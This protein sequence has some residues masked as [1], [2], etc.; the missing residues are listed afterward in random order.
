VA[1]GLVG[2]AIGTETF[3]SILAPAGICGA[4]GLRPTFGRVSRHGVMTLSWTLDK[5]GPLC[6]SVE[7]G[8]LVLAAIQ[9]PDGQDLSVQDVPFN[10]DA[11]RDRRSLRVG[12]LKA[13]FEKTNQSE[14][15]DANDA[16]ALAKLRG[17]GFSL[18]EVTLPETI[19]GLLR[20]IQWSEMNAALKEPY[21]TQPEELIRK[22]RMARM[23]GIRLFPAAD[24]LDA[25]RVRGLLMRD[26]ARLMSEVDVYVVPFD[27]GDYTPNEVAVANTAVTNLTGQPAV[28][29]PH[30]FDEKGHPTS[31]TFV[32]RVFGEAEMLAAAKAYQDSTGWHERHPAL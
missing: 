9:G 23:N 31:L 17:L 22:D 12:Y 27:Y 13:A 30:G 32:G 20:A 2:F 15:T 11:R 1:A 7:D 5:V 3:G 16:A 25:N 8:A 10:W 14:R 6:R 4:T 18:T 24:Y 29:V 26:M 19:G 28:I 21:R